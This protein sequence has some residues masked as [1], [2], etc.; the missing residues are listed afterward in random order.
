[1]GSYYT[2]RETFILIFCLYHSLKF[3]KKPESLHRQ[4]VVEFLVKPAR[5]ILLQGTIQMETKSRLLMSKKTMQLSPKRAYLLTDVLLVL[6]PYQKSKF[7]VDHWIELIHARI[8]K[9]ELETDII[10]NN[11]NSNARPVSMA[12]SFGLADSKQTHEPPPLACIEIMW[13]SGYI[14]L[15]YKTVQDCEIWY[16][17]ILTACTSAS[18]LDSRYHIDA[19]S[20]EQTSLPVLHKAVLSRNERKLKTALTN[21]T[22]GKSTESIDEIDNHGYTALHYTCIYRWH[23]LME[24]ICVANV[25]VCLLDL[26]GLSPLHWSALQLDSHAL[27]ILLKNR[28]ESIDPNVRCKIEPRT[29]LIIACSEGFDIKG[30]YNGSA[31]AD[32]LKVLLVHNADPDLCDADDVAPLHHLAS[33]WKWEGIREFVVNYKISGINAYK[34]SG[35]RGCTALHHAMQAVS[36]DKHPIRELLHQAR[37]VLGSHQHITA[38]E[39]MAAAAL[40]LVG[41]NNS[42]STPSH[43]R[44]ADSPFTPVNSP[45]AIDSAVVDELSPKDVDATLKEAKLNTP[46]NYLHGVRTLRALL[47]S[48]CRPNSRNMVGK[49]PLQLIFQHMHQWGRVREAVCVLLM[50]GARPTAEMI[51]PAE[52]NILK[53]KCCKEINNPI[54]KSRNSTNL[55]H[56]K[57]GHRHDIDR[58]SIDETRSEHST[59]SSIVED[60]CIDDDDE[61][62]LITNDMTPEKAVEYWKKRTD[63][64]INVEFVNLG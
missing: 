10:A 42:N 20:S 15:L 49:T 53:E 13:P 52:F 50:Y 1:M 38:T 25:D 64:G 11:G 47:R 19:S 34:F 28:G 60:N 44:I 16:D 43:S 31:L 39:F 2:Y 8:H 46:R 55:R 57:Q 33:G 12:F 29:P 5:R 22:S 36:R 62:A 32:C 23:S 45:V 59:T 21:I 17:A 54:T 18:G 61:W 3:T 40:S 58:D 4:D 26:Q 14:K 63:T 6:E 7:R 41:F 30:E 24:A 51:D 9:S 56:S 48:G 27:S 35:S 37:H